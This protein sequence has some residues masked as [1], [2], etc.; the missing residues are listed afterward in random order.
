VS[1]GSL[2]LPAAA[3]GAILVAWFA[4]GARRGSGVFYV[5]F[6]C[7]VTISVQL[8][9]IFLVFATLIVPALATRYAAAGRMPKAYAVA[10]AGYALGLVISA[11]FD[12][13]SGPTVVWAMAIAGVVAALAER[14]ARVTA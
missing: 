10:V 7:A 3:S 6:A 11:L 12:A 2:A 13:P 1:F 4:G 9:G 8:V 5:L 14:H